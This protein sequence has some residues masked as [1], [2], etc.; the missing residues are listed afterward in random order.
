MRI[1]NLSPRTITAYVEKVAK[2]ARHFGKSPEHLGP[3][4]IRTY[5]LGLVDARRARSTLVQNVCALRF[6]YKVTLRRP[7]QDQVLPFPKKERH[8]PVVLSREEVRAL[9]EA[10]GGL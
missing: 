10:P 9:L 3:E 8:L 2:F 6:L 7:W 5:L 1:R 4:D